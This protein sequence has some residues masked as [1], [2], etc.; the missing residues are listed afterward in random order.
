MVTKYIYMKKIIFITCLVFVNLL[1]IRAQDKYTVRPL[2]PQEVS[3]R[4]LPKYA[5]LALMP[6]TQ[7]EYEN[8]K[9]VR[10]KEKQ[11][12]IPLLTNADSV[13][14]T[15]RNVPGLKAGDPDIPVR[16]YKP[17]Y[18]ATAPIF[19]WFHGG[20]FVYG[21]LNGD[22]KHC[23]NMAIRGKVVVISVDYRLAPEHPYPAA[24]H[25]AYAVFL[26]SIKNAKNFQGDT[27]RIGL[28]GGS[29]G[30]GVAGSM[31]L[32]NRERK[33]PK[34]ALQA[35][36]FPPADIDTNHVS[37]RE[38]W[39]I[40]GVKGAD[41]PYLLKLYIGKDYASNIPKN[42]LP[43]MTDN[44]SQLPPTYIATCGVD[45]LRDGGLDLGV[46]LIKAGIP[47]EL[48]NF[49]GYP[50]GLLPDRVFP[51]LYSFMYEYFYK[52]IK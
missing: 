16:I 26:W 40:P 14:I 51:E 11:S 41:I 6:L 36:F 39:Q 27:T 4:L 44:F 31:T 49:P 12:T 7:L 1:G 24:V 46:K 34:I 50:H 8:I 52:P 47:V 29:A 2:T 21:N 43:G 3:Q 15:Y 45:P 28:G 17:K 19:L 23:A 35:L 10:E 48:H 37:V 13:E 38:L 25:D 32:L 18:S 20:G 22:H 30:A 42:V 5:P 33:G 9:S